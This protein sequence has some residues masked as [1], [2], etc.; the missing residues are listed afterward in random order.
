LFTCSASA[1]ISL[2]L[3]PVDN[4]ALLTGYSTYDLHI[5]TDTDWTVA[6]GLL[7][8]TAG[9]IY[10][11]TQGGDR[12]VPS[13]R[14]V[15]AY[16]DLVFDTYVI[17]NIAGGAGDIGGD[18]FVFSDSQLSV[19][20]FNIENTDIGTTTIGRLTLSDDA[21]GSLSMVLGAAGME[22]NEYDVTF[23]PGVSPMLSEMVQEIE[24]IEDKPELDWKNEILLTPIDWLTP[25]EPTDRYSS[26]PY[27]RTPYVVP[28]REDAYSSGSWYFRS[29]VFG[30]GHE[31]GYLSE[32]EVLR[33]R[34][35]LSIQNNNVWNKLSFDPPQESSPNLLPEP[36]ALMLVG[37][38][39]G[40][41]AIR[42]R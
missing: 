19:S 4:S 8:L 38:G 28:S 15:S 32:Y 6:A 1:S 5:T 18:G 2:D 13:P 7:D 40:V 25:K 9:S 23:S 29:P 22:H 16:P 3:T 24:V 12:G 34:R 11:H 20:W 30:D 26:N 36:G 17:G 37:V 33:D 21:E 42:R 27:F 41:T 10:Q 31:H 35:R 14:L 39:L